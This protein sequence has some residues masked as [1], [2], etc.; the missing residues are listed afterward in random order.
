[1]KVLLLLPVGREQSQCTKCRA[2]TS[3]TAQKQHSL[4]VPWSSPACDWLW[5]RWKRGNKNKT[6]ASATS[7]WHN[8]VTLD[9]TR[10]NAPAVLRCSALF[11]PPAHWTTFTLPPPAAWSQGQLLS[12]KHLCNGTR[13]RRSLCNCFVIRTSRA[14]HIRRA[15][16]KVW[17]MPLPCE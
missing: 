1:M 4:Y 8:T 10:R 17:V 11:Y 9:G 16:G 12:Q 2:K 7:V 15:T 13:C 3:Q 6:T 14:V 5:K